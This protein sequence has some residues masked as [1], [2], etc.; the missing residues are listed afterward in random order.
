MPEASRHTK[1]G[2]SSDHKVFPDP[3]ERLSLQLP[4]ENLQQRL[5]YIDDVLGLKIIVVAFTAGLSEKVVRR[6]REPDWNPTIRTALT[7]D[8][9]ISQFMPHWIE[10]ARRARDGK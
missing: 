10:A 1:R 7:L 9:T 4:I 3:P 6:Y 8:I 5:A 2:R